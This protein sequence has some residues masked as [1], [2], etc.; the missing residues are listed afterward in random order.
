MG[1]LEDEH[2]TPALGTM[3]ARHAR[4]ALKELRETLRDRRTIVTLVL[5]PVLVYPLL[6]MTFQRFLLG[7]LPSE[8]GKMPPTMVALENQISHGLLLDY[9]QSGILMAGEDER[10]HMRFNFGETRDLE[11]AVRGGEATIGIRLRR[12]PGQPMQFE[13]LYRDDPH[14]LEAAR[15]METYLQ[16]AALYELEEQLQPGDAATS[17]APRLSFRAVKAS[18]MLPSSLATLVPL[19]L[20]LM[21]ITG[22]VYPAIDLT[23]GER[24]R[25]TLETLIAAPI[26]RLSLLLSKYVAVVCVALLTASINLV[27]M[28]VT[29]QLSGLGPLLFGSAGISPDTIIRVFSLLVLFAA[30]FSAILLS[31]TSVARSFKEA[32]AYLIPLMLVAIAPGLLSM[33]PGLE[34]TPG[35]AAVPLV[36]IVL[37]ARDTF[38]GD[39]DA[40]LTTIAVLTTMFY[41]LA[42][43]GFAAKVFGRDAILY[44]SHRSWSD[45]LERPQRAL[46]APPLGQALLCLALL[47]P[48]QFLLMGVIA[49]AENAALSWRLITSAM[50]T[51]ILFVGLPAIVMALGKICWQS[52]ARLRNPPLLAWPA[53]IVLG[54]LLWPLAHE[55]VR[56]S[57]RVGLSNLSDEQIRAVDKLLANSQELPL[58]LIIVCFGVIPGVCEELFFRG[59]LFSALRQKLTPAATIISAA[60][61]FASFHLVTSTLLAT[62]RFLPSFGLGI[63]LGWLA[64]RSGSVLPSIVMHVLH[65][66]LLLGLIPWYEGSVTTVADISDPGTRLPWPWFAA[67]AAA[68]LVAVLLLLPQPRPS[69]TASSAVES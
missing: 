11:A 55:A 41:A 59:Y 66:S 64:Y 69:E 17:R 68:V 24:E 27:A 19:I 21:T 53:A 43:I 34:L 1:A 45:L 42:A 2:R 4:L 56:F 58:A 5:M 44:G 62:E 61:L 50:A 6:S 65:N 48:A 20:I 67:S 14:S 57:Q 47:F 31:I 3:V 52:A 7:G 35:L 33:A 25:G 16:R 63:A 8:K 40:R 22:A 60:L 38:Y 28:S 37:V 46:A 9:A 29:V 51:A 32:Q 49:R 12:E 39:A 26:S 30:F 13:I 15:V 23:A 54:G 10:E 18:A 36:N